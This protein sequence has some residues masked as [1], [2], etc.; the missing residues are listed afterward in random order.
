MPLGVDHIIKSEVPNFIPSLWSDEVIAGYKANLVMANLVRKLNHKGK[1]GDSIRIPTPTRGVSSA[2][3]AETQ[4]NLI[5]HGADAGITININRHREYSRL[6]E[7]IVDVQALES[8]RRFYTDDAGYSL[9][10]RTDYDLIIEAA[11]FGNGGGTIVEEAVTGEIDSTSTFTNARIGD[12]S[13]AWTPTASANAGNAVD[14]NDL[15]IRRFIRRLD[16]VDA[17]MAG[18]VLVVPPVTKA[19]MMGIARFT[20][21]SFTGE[22]GAG[23]TI[24]N[25]L[26]GNVYGVDVFVTSQMPLV[27]DAGTN[28]DQQL[29]LFFQR[30]ALVLVEQLGVRVQE[31]YKQEFLASLMTA[32]MIYGVKGVR[33]TSI[34]PIVVPVAFTD[35]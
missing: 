28:N 18:R 3:V 33:S 8:L 22:V 15:G 35:G 9:A 20:N 2:K 23:N 11:A 27:E 4:V 30:D 10:R 1:K 5:Q 14:L 12:D 16:D 32:D 7:D 19:D 31:Q 13:A 26:V 17:P 29:A 34:I 25:G 24:R 6:I 21:Q